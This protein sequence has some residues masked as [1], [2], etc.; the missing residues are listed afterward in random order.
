MR[1]DDAYLYSIVVAAG[2]LGVGF[3]EEVGESLRCCGNEFQNMR[4]KRVKSWTN[5]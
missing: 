5:R 4:D 2:L 3:S 1:L